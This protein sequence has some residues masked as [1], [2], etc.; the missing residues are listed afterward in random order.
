MNVNLN[1]AATISIDLPL[2]PSHV[3]L[4]IPLVNPNNLTSKDTVA[5]DG[6]PSMARELPADGRL[7]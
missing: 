5:T 2:Q 6:S 3:C 7:R 1:F 4:P